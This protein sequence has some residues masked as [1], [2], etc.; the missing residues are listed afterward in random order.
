MLREERR[1]ILGEIDS[2]LGN[3]IKS[4]K[5]Q[6]YTNISIFS[7]DIIKI[8]KSLI[9]HLSDLQRTWRLFWV[10]TTTVIK[11][12]LPGLPCKNLNEEPVQLLILKTADIV[13]ASYVTHKELRVIERFNGGNSGSGFIVR[14][15]V[16]I[17]QNIKSLYFDDYFRY[18]MYLRN[19][20]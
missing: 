17:T 14:P 12:T 5:G 1:M 8:F 10:P 15:P 11:V 16:S 18:N 3:G 2:Q 4:E 19:G 13:L 6:I 9:C 7:I 20:E